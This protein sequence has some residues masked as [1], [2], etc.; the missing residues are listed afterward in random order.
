MLTTVAAM[1]A[2]LL[3]LSP[4]LSQFGLL[5]AIGI[6]YAYVTSLVVLPPAIVVWQRLVSVEASDPLRVSTDA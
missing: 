4:I 5:M 2:L 1:L 6:A 3:A